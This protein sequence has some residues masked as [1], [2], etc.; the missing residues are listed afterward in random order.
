M[1]GFFG[2]TIDTGDAYFLPFG[3]TD[4]LDPTLIE[5]WQYIEEIA[6]TY[7][8]GVIS[9]TPTEWTIKNA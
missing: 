7:F 3:S 2:K 1:T 9:R 4:A 8:R 6:P 5:K